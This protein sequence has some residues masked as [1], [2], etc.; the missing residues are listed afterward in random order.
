MVSFK[1]YCIDLK[2]LNEGRSAF[3][4]A[5]DDRFFRAVESTD[6]HGGKLDA[7]VVVQKTSSFFELTF[8]IAGEVTIACSK[9]LDDM[10]QPIETTERMLVRFGE[11]YEELDELVVVSEAEGC[12]DVSWFIYE[13]IMLDIPIQHV[14]EPGKCNAE[15]LDKLAQH[16]ATQKEETR[17]IDPRWSKLNELKNK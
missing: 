11:E 3:H 14:H 13:L 10:Q 7:E 6:I 12:I 2:A 5:I 8:H 4:Y 9:C 1:E 15:M 17:E 16:S